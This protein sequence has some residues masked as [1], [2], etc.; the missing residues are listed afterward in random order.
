LLIT[1]SA[2]AQLTVSGTVY[3][4]SK[5]IPVKNVFVKSTGGNLTITDSTG[6]YNINVTEKDSLTFTYL[7]KPTARFAVKQIDNPGSFDISLH[8][9]LTEKFRTL[10]EVR[11]FSKNYRQDSIANRE[12]Y[13]KI[14]NYHR[15]GIKTSTSEYSGSSGL[16]LD[17]FINIFRFKRN[18]R[19]KNMQNRLLEQEQE[20]YINFRFNRPLVKRMTHLDGTSLD[21]FMV[22]YRPDFE[23]TQNSSTVNF[24]QYILNAS[25]RFKKEMMIEDVKTTAP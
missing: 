18:K 6:H 19:L 2:A 14:F 24:Y 20:S 13:A 3:D 7:N 11:V 5:I 25:Y 15:P 16:D 8:I 1:G 9:R 4:S 10:K 22:R 21:I 23:F 17:E 12:E